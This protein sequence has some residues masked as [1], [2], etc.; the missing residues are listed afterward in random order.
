MVD[1]G[2]RRV[3]RWLEVVEMRGGACGNDGGF[4]CKPLELVIM[5]GGAWCNGNHEVGAR[6]RLML[7]VAWGMARRERE[8]ENGVAWSIA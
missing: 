7:R 6:C 4:T 8:R 5:E 3:I 2:G 1:G